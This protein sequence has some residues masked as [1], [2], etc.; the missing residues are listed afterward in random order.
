MDVA[1]FWNDVVDDLNA[2]D[3]TGDPIPGNQ[4]GPTRTSR[5]GALAMLALHDAFF[6]IQGK[7][8]TY[9]GSLPPASPNASPQFAAS[10]ACAKVLS[11]LYPKH[12]AFIDE[13]LATAPRGSGELHGANTYGKA[14]GD[15]LIKLREGDERFDERHPTR[16]SHCQTPIYG[17]HRVDPANP[18]QG[19]LNPYWGEM[20]LLATPAA[21]YLAPPPG[22]NGAGGLNANDTVYKAHHQEVYERGGS[23]SSAATLRTPEETVIGIFW[24]YDGVQKLGTPPRL[25][26]RLVKT[27]AKAKALTEEQN[28]RLLTL[29]NVAMAD[30]GI[31]A[32][33]YKYHYDLW[34]PIVG[35]REYTPSYGPSAE[36]GAA[37]LPFSDPFWKPLGAPKTNDP[38]GNNF[39]PGF[40]AYPSGHATFGAAAMHMT[41]LYLKSI[42]KAEIHSNGCD[43]VAFDFISEELDGLAQDA[44]GSVRTRHVRRFSSLLQAIVENSVSRVY[45]GVH[46]RFDGTTG[47]YDSSST[48]AQDATGVFDSSEDSPV[49]PRDAI[50]G[51]PLGLDIAEAIFKGGLKPNANAV[52]LANGLPP[53]P[54]P[55]YKREPLRCRHGG[56][57]K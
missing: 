11:W 48:K 2:R 57:K 22:L 6:G 46:W 10:A 27:I 35:V 19:F 28:L 42:G 26:N 8:T 53:P 44:D 47:G 41:R 25:Y 17:H 3:H 56:K 18:G 45:L 21:V 55:S 14:V 52:S 43:D 15:A 33:F 54:D 40:P 4:A 38:K 1:I 49:A 13:K 36:P 34:R 50:G 39:T 23:A 24:A 29:V 31:H 51:V 20:P 5:A 12:R 9:L 7:P 32:W 37:R 16:P 30:A